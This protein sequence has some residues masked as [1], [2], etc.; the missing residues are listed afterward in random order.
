M[1][2]VENLWKIIVIILILLISSAILYL[3]WKPSP[4]LKEF[5]FIPNWVAELGDLK[6]NNAKRTGAAM[7]VIAI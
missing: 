7:F 5:A 4:V 2:L 3:S 1:N 6:Q